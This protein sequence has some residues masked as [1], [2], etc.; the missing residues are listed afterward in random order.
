ML[1]F[2]IANSFFKQAIA[3]GLKVQQLLMIKSI[4]CICLLAPVLAY[5]KDRPWKQAGRHTLRIISLRGLIAICSIF[6]YNFAFKFMPLTQVNVI[7]MV[8]PFIASVFGYLINREPVLRVEKIAMVVSFGAI[9][10]FTL[11]KAEEPTA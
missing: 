7:F 5:K 1:A 2:V 9:V 8:Y 3:Q 11:S 4:L 6:A 10:L